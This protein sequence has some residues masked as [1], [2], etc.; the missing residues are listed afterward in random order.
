MRKISIM[1]KLLAAMLAVGASAPGWACGEAGNTRPI[2]L[3]VSQQA[4]GST[5]TLARM[6]AETASKELGTTVLVENK[7]GAGGVI[8]AKY[9]LSQPADGCTLFLAGVSQMVLNK[10]AYAPLSY[11]PET[12]FTPVSVLTTVPFVL[13]ANP[14]TG[15]HTLADLVA[16]ARAKPGKINF[17]SSGNGNSTHLVVELFQKNQNIHMTHVPYKGEPDGVVAT[18]GGQTQVMA[19]VLSTA[20]P[21]IRAGKLVPL[22]LFAPKRLPDLPDVPTAS[23]LGLSGLDDL[24]WMGVAAKGGTSP[25]VVKRLH[26]VSQVFL[27]DKGTLDKLKTMQVVPMPGPSG[28]LM[29]M[30]VRDTA[31]VQDA[32]GS[33]DFQSR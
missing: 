33:V 11:K 1:G 30:T 18:V 7:A 13:V 2:K 9:V 20:M 6:W 27:A 25:D 21:Q 24:G 31:K 8:A 29:Q 5:D 32:L 23:E 28:M 10:F 22:V 16:A 14:Q 26:A 19:P 3:V 17:A 12:D 4:G 15:F